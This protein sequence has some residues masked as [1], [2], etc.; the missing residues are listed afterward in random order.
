LY[1]MW[2]LNRDYGYYG[3]D[4]EELV[5]WAKEQA[6]GELTG[7]EEWLRREKFSLE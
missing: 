3:G 7:L 4:M 1:E 2:V 5:Q 6:K